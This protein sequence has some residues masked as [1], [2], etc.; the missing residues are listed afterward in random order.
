MRLCR[1]TSTKRV[2]WFRL[3]STLQ[4]Q[5]SVRREVVL[6]WLKLEREHTRVKHAIQMPAALNDSGASDMFVKVPDSLIESNKQSGNFYKHM[7]PP[8]P[9]EASHLPG[10]VLAQRAPVGLRLVHAGT[11]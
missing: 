2:L 10:G 6:A 5:A 3:P 9:D 8:S 11:G 4:A 1:S 7:P